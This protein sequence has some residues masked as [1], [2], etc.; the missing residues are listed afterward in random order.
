[1][2]QKIASLF[3]EIGAD[4]SKLETGLKRSKSD[5]G[6][7]KAG[8][9]DVVEGLSGFNLGAIGVAGAAVALGNTVRESIS[10]FS[11]Y[12]EAMDKM[13]MATG[14]SIE[15]TSRLVQVADD[16]R[17]EQ[18]AVEQAMK[19]ALQNGFNPSIGS[20][21]E[22]SDKYRS[23]QDPTKRAAEMQKVFG[24]SWG[25]M[26]PLLEKGG[27]AIRK[28][29]AEMDKGMIVTR[30]AVEANRQFQKSMDD[31]A[32]AWTSAQ[33]D[34]AKS[35]IPTLAFDLKI[36]ASNL[37]DLSSGVS[38][39]KVLA[40][41]QEEYYLQERKMANAIGDYDDAQREAMRATLA[42]SGSVREAADTGREGAE[43]LR[44]L[45]DGAEFSALMYQRLSVEAGQNVTLLGELKG[46]QES[47]AQAEQAWADGAGS[48]SA[49]MLNEKT[50]GAQAYLEGLGAIDEVMGTHLKQQEEQKDALEAAAKAYGKT[51]DLDAY[52]TKLN[53]IK[54]TYAPL[55][56]AVESS[57][58]LVETFAE[59][60]NAL[61]SKNLTLR[62][63]LDDIPDTGG[64]DPYKKKHGGESDGATGLDMIVPSGF[65]SD[66]Y[67][68]GVTSGE[69]VVVTPN[70]AGGPSSTG[71]ST[72][73]ITNLNLYGI[74]D[75][76]KLERELGRRA[77]LAAKSGVR[78]SGR[79]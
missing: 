55:D 1:M 73:T 35:V 7:F 69:H 64:G 77:N 37:D 12:A 58:K 62:V 15:E 61:E 42:A 16:F 36:V 2:G 60:W 26:V 48:Q 20:I 6:N 68:I 8:L 39:F 13:S 56:E 21:A 31:L 17:V 33:N 46:A 76:H 74:Q 28:A 78:F 38:I 51:H 29:A 3:A 9:K 79:S 52:K 71:G 66:S 59:Q 24:K 23:I 45:G 30:D 10:N 50:L 11:N 41:N 53:E 5:L 63:T 40:D 43:S 18:G 27:E 57:T 32:D 75:I 65:P 34:L 22:L 67:K 49:G 72:Y 47:L 25:D 70:S 19:M 14:M 54:D 4:T 44:D